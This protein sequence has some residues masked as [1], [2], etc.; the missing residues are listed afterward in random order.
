MSIYTPT[1]AI[2]ATAAEFDDGDPPEGAC[3]NPLPEAALDTAH[4]ASYRR[5]TEI[6]SNDDG[7]SVLGDNNKAATF[8]TGTVA[9]WDGIVQPLDWV[10]VQVSFQAATDAA[11]VQEYRLSVS[12]AVGAP[13]ALGGAR[14]QFDVLNTLAPVTLRAKFQS[15][16]SDHM[17]IWIESRAPNADQD[18]YVKAPM[19]V[20]GYV[21]RPLP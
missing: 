7:T 13:T 15:S 14:A 21:M 11:S 8:G 16:S 18:G 4:W 1:A 9:V 6:D 17:Y 19:R 3:I 10:D 2:R 20:T 12:Y 5:H